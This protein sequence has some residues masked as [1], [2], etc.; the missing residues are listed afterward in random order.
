[1]L[2]K[3]GNRIDRRNP[4]DIFTPLYNKQ[5]PPGA[6]QVVHY[7]L[8]VP[9][10]VTGPV[11]IALK[12]RYRKFDDRYMELV[13]KEAG[14]P[15]PKLPI[16]DI[17][18]DRVT[19]P[20][21][22]VAENVPVQ[23]SPIKPAWQRWNDYGIGCFIE[24]GAGSKKGNLRQAE[25]A[26][27][28]LLT[29]DVKDARWHGHLNL[30]R[31]YIDQGRLSEASRELNAAQTS[32]PPAPWW[33]LSWFKGLVTAQNAT[34]RA[35]LDEAADLFAKIVDPANQ[36]RLD[37]GKL[38]Y[39]FTRDYVVL[40]E[41]GRTLYKRSTLEP[42][43]AETERQFLLRAVDAYERA[44]V[45]DPEELDAHYGLNQCYDRLGHGAAPAPPPTGP[46]HAERLNELADR[47]VKTGEP[48]A[49]RQTTAG[50]LAAA[51]LAF[52]TR[53]P[54]PHNP[55]LPMLRAL[56]AQ[57]RPAFHDE[58]DPAVQT[59]IAA[60]LANLHLVSH[61][62]YTPDDLARSK[63]TAIY[64]QKHPAANAAAEAIVL[65]PA[66]R[67]GAPGLAP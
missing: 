23:E 18:E 60:V 41:L 64:R 62:L 16:V 66:N 32:D 19:L 42:Q 7:T 48:S 17:C 63:A 46:V 58:K 45:V 59:S 36:P 37:N 56:L 51:V 8:S 21:A 14:K 27:A 43:G 65:Y 12:L 53:P 4:Q 10:D 30:A 15:I 44:L 20:V 34:T 39:D 38:K 54:D 40:T 28:K 25:A 26:F 13:H 6:G 11:E 9:R 61:S 67:P 22:G 50:E 49:A 29:L 55:K 3:D 1:M 24:G 52:G 33:V 35:D 2:D 5:I 57:L 47:L 31:V